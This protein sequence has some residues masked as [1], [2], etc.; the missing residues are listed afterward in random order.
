[1]LRTGE[2]SGRELR[3]FAQFL[4]LYTSLYEPESGKPKYELS[5]TGKIT[6]T[7]TSFS[8]QNF[9]LQTHLITSSPAIY[10]FCE[11]LSFSNLSPVPPN[12]A[13]LTPAHVFQK[14]SEILYSKKSEHTK[15]ENVVIHLQANQPQ[16]IEHGIK[17]FDELVALLRKNY[18]DLFIIVVTGYGDKVNV[19]LPFGRP[20]E[21][22]GSAYD[23]IK[24]IIP[25][26]SYTTWHGKALSIRE[27]SP[28][29]AVYYHRH[30]TRKDA[31]TSFN[32]EG[33]AQKNGNG[34]MPADAFF[35]EVAFKQGK[36]PKYG[37]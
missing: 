21:K 12:F 6:S 5:D 1:M 23:K 30:F 13:E 34:K 31:V 15:V 7:E 3:E 25:V 29:F 16:S 11:N 2:A 18:E 36:M 9:N 4:S 19:E 20:E 17:I 33:F 32:L 8:K 26:Q 24:Y 37:A 22:I 27:T 10:H 14:I 35:H 28:L